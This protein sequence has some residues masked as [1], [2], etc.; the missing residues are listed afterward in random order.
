[1]GALGNDSKYGTNFGLKSEVV[2]ARQKRAAGQAMEQRV[3]RWLERKGLSFVQCNVSFKAGEIDLV[4]R[5]GDVLVFVEVRSRSRSH[6]GYAIETIDW[7]KQ[8]TLLAAVS[9]YLAKFHRKAM[10]A[11]RIDVV[12]VDGNRVFCLRQS[13]VSIA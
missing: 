13:M 5:D 11:C 9:L 2:S 3:R 6:W 10:P 8:K 12:T 1:M 4:M 7:R